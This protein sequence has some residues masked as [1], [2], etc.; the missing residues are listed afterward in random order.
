MARRWEFFIECHLRTLNVRQRTHW[1][2]LHRQDTRLQAGLAAQFNVRVPKDALVEKPHPRRR[3][4]VLIVRERLMDDDALGAAAK[5]LMDVLKT[6]RQRIGGPKGPVVTVW[7]GVVYDDSRK[8][9]RITF[10]QRTLRDVGFGAVEGVRI[11][12]EEDTP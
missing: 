8:Y 4:D 5:P 2:R 6:R 1:R 11:I 3:I 10:D 12:V 9:A 7:H